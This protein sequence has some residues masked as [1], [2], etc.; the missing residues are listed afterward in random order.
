MIAQVR[1]CVTVSVACAGAGV[2][3]FSPVAP[4]HTAGHAVEA[5]IQLTAVPSPLVLY[6]QVIVR[7][8][9]NTAALVGAYFSDPLPL[10]RLTIEKQGAALAAAVEAI[11]A[12]DLAA[13]VKAVGDALLQPIRTAFGAVEYF[14][15]LINQPDAPGALFQIAF[16]PFLSGVAALGVA[17]GD[18]IDAAMAFDLVGMV[19]AVI[20]IPARVIDGVLNGGYG[21]PFGDFDNLP[22]LLTP[23][24]VEGYLAPGPIALAITIDQDA[25]DYIE[26]QDDIADTEDSEGAADAVDTAGAATMDTES[27]DET[28]AERLSGSGEADAAAEELELPVDDDA[29]TDDINESVAEVEAG[30]E[31]PIPEDAAVDGDRDSEGDAGDGDSAPQDTNTDDAGG[32]ES[33]NAA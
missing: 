26:E 33:V 24:T 4:V 9:Q 30:E 31:A 13:A 23:L 29:A 18:V 6:P 19:N 16:S 7:S 15:I 14:D 8:V 10:T 5:G 11:G 21:S 27:A 20:N 25:A 12:G 17:I 2:I 32:P 28:D 3:A 1:T 22:G